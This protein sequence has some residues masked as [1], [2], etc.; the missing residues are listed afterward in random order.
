MYKRQLFNSESAD[1]TVKSVNYTSG[2]ETLGVDAAGYT[3]PASGSL[4]IPFRYTPTTAKVMTITVTVLMEQKGV[5]YEYAMDV[6][7]DVLDSAKL[8]YI[9][10]DA[11]HSESLLRVLSSDLNAAYSSSLNGLPPQN[12]ASNCLPVK[13]K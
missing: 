5:E 7:L 10:I 4:Q 8:V 6:T 1:A 13:E 11:S 9:G 2:G 12:V 3:V